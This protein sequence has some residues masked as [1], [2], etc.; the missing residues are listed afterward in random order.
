MKVRRFKCTVSDKRGFNGDCME[1]SDKG[2]YIL[3]SDFLKFI[4]KIKQEKKQC[5][6]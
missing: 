4:S 1:K 6:N 5:Q 3:Y 2:D